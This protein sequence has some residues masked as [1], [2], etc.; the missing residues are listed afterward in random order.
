MP[1][2][3]E[4][5]QH[6]RELFKEYAESLSLDLSFQDFEHEFSERPGG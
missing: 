3:K 1:A 2:A 6:I 5:L 4:D